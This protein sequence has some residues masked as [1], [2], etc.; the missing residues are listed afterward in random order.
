MTA[1]GKIVR[2]RSHARH[3]LT[4]KPRKR[5]RKLTSATLVSKSDHSRIKSMLNG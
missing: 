4:K 5:L 3:I 1:T 2:R